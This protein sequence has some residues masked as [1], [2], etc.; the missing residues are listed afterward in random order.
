MEASNDRT[1]GFEPA[2]GSS[3]EDASATAGWPRKV[4]L[5]SDGSKHADRAAEVL[6]AFV[7]SGATVR[8][9]TV[10]GLEFAPYEGRWGPLSDEPER[11]ARLQ[12]LIENA[13]DLPLQNLKKTDCQ[14]EKSTRFG[15]PAEQIMEEIREWQ[16]D[17]VVVG[18]AGVGGVVKLLLGS[19]SEH[20]VK[21][22]KVP[23]LVVP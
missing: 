18:R 12:S 17:L 15:N 1:P 2:A 4:L 16:P 21:H 23:V 3:T 11:Q 6:A 5:A 13:F 22:A 7:P 14:I 20:V 9:L 8:L 19:V 10:A